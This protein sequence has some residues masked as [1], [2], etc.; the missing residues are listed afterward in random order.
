[1]VAVFCVI[2]ALAGWRFALHPSGFLPAEDQG[3]AMVVVRCPDAA[4]QPR[5]RE[6]SAKVDAILKKTP[7]VTAWVTIGGFSILDSANLSNIFTSF[8]ILED[9]EKRGDGLEPGTDRRHA[10]PGSGRHPGSGDHGAGAAAH[11]RAG[12]V[13]GLPD[14]GGRP[15]SPGPAG[16]GEGRHGSDPGRQRPSRVSGGWPPPSAP[17][18]PSSI[19]TS[20]APRRSP[21]RYPLNNV[22]DTLQAYLGSSFVNLFNKFNQVFQV[23][24]QADAPLPPAARRTSRDLYVRNN[25]GEMVPLGTLLNGQAHPGRGAGHPLQS[26]S[27]RG[28]FSGPRRRD[29][30]PARP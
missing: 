11:Q 25:R 10:A 18:A 20:T 23:Y 7:G 8:V 16:T 19:W 12:A 5:V 26:L 17:T 29:S 2:I 6:A 21:W 27:R 28:R 1:M 22:F 14:D 24:V 13:R 9:M 15:E 3:Y 4:S 30:A